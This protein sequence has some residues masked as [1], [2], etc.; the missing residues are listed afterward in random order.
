MRYALEGL[1]YT[2][3]AVR[4]LLRELADN[5]PGRPQLRLA[6]RENLPHDPESLAQELQLQHPLAAKFTLEVLSYGNNEVRQ[7]N[8]I[9]D[10]L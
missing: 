10:N 7:R 4:L 3:E 9:S 1:R 5:G 2:G 8:N 6:P